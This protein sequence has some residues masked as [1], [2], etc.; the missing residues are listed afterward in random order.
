MYT[1]EGVEL[2]PAKDRFPVSLKGNSTVLW[3][4]QEKSATSEDSSTPLLIRISELN[5]KNM[6][7]MSNKQLGLLL[8]YAT[9]F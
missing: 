7:A 3:F 9:L 5:G 6:S 4:T 2:R 1:I 8:F